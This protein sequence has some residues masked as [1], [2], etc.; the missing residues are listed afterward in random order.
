MSGVLGS[1][2]RHRAWAPNDDRIV[3]LGL[4]RTIDETIGWDVRIEL[5]W[6]FV[7]ED[8]RAEA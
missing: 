6:R 2:R 5:C 4:H 1:S 3:R 8:A 7:D